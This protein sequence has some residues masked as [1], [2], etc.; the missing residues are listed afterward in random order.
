MFLAQHVP[1]CS[2]RTA[3]RAI[4]AGEVRINGRRARKGDR[5]RPQDLVQVADTLYASPPLQ[6][7]PQLALPI[8]YEDD[9]MIAV[10]KPA[11]MPSQA[12]SAHERETVANFLLA[13]HP[14]VAGIEKGGREAGLVHRLDVETSGVLLAA[15]TA[16]A[17]RALRQQFSRRQV[18]KDYVA[19]VEGEV[20]VAG[21]VDT[22]IAHDR[23]NPRRMRVTAP[24]DAHGRP[25]ITHFDPIERHPML[26]VVRVRIPTGVMHQIR[27]HLASIGHPI[28]GDRMYGA[29]AEPASRRLLH[30]ASLS[31]T[32]PTAGKAVRIHSPLP[33]D[34][35][36]LL[37][38]LRRGKP[39][40][41]M[42]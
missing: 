21:I 4:A 12:L 34:F 17:Y 25:A 6:A 38:A 22:P 28:V 35:A 10:D 27:V 36:A 32:H 1:A 40:A 5:V 31:V 9:A 7:N 20:R 39:R 16:A 26:T 19:L 33:A 18:V 11:G 24:G 23:R 37:H 2:R 14:E 41:K 30:A 29:T 8:L 3:Q 13:R 15:R 42:G